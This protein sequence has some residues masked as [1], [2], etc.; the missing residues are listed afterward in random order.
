MAERIKT[1]I[2][3]A[4]FLELP[5]SNLPRQ[6][7]DGEI[8]DMAAP[9]LTHQDIV[10]N[11]GIFF[12]RVEKANG[13]KTYIAPVDVVLDD[14]NVPQP[15]ALY[16]VPGSRCQ[17][18]G[19]RRLQGPPD[20]IVEVLS[21][22]SRILDR[23]DKFR[24]YQRAQVREYWIVDPEERQIEVWQHDGERYA[25]LG[26]VFLPGETF[27]SAIVGVVSTDALFNG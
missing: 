24:L 19:S 4:E 3:A 13:G 7:L 23:R 21:P 12:R 14:Y 5:E 15:D 16:L 8:I 17:P 1:R 9:E 6:L 25:R 27:T 10:L 20:L 22:G 11:L 18:Q 2:P 26:D